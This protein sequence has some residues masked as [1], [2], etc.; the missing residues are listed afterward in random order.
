MQGIDLSHW[1][2][3]PLNAV[4]EKAFAESDFVI[5]KLTNGSDTYKYESWGR[6]IIERALKEGKLAG[7]YHYAKGGDP[8]K[9]AAEFVRAV[10]PYLGRIILALDWERTGNEAWGST[11]WAKTFADAVHR[12]TGVWPLIYTGYEGCRQC[13]SCFPA[14]GLWYA[15]YK[16]VS[17]WKV[18]EWNAAWYTAPWNAYTIWQY[19]SSGGVDRNTSSLTPDGWRALCEQERKENMGKI[20]T[21][22]AFV[23]KAKHYIGY[24]EKASAVSLEDFHANRGNR[25]Y[26][27]FQKEV[28]AGNGSAWCQYFVDACAYEACG[29]DLDKAREMLCMP[30]GKVMSGYTKECAGFFEKAGRFYKVPKVGDIVYFYYS[31]MG[32][33]AH[34]GIVVSVDTSAKT[35]RTVEGN[36][37]SSEYSRNGGAVAGHTYSYKTVGGTA[38][39]AG[40]GRPKF[41]DGDS[42]PDTG[43]DLLKKGASGESVRELQKMLIAC[44]YSCGS[45]GADGVFGRGTV[46][47]LKAF[48]RK[49]GLD[50]DGIYGP[51]SREALKKAYTAKNS[52]KK[53]QK[54]RVKEFQAWMNA[55]YAEVLL[56]S[57]RKSEIAVD[58]E[59]GTE[60]RNAALGIWKYM[61]A[62]YFGGKLTISNHAFGPAC[63]AV[64]EKMK[65]GIGYKEHPTLAILMQ[66]LLACRGDYDYAVDGVVGEGTIG[67]LKRY[68]AKRLLEQS[69]VC[70]AATWSALFY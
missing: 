27:K 53:T 33:I 66:G 51:K 22:D 16:T 57:V 2:G 52:D 58:G 37:S 69:G 40:F 23:A 26:T 5:A 19:T 54:D 45:A 63:R 15:R 50:A 25:N 9:E 61:A 55:H 32:R 42:G 64:A 28:G 70:D 31:S 35:F 48:Q 17:T 47:A 59:Y 12:E 4:S 43:D 29:N 49:S 67:C 41:A 30:A 6:N 24:E 60:T 62:K 8:E 38:H 14:C 10:R 44:G 36:T 65:V 20:A 13:A 1:N 34:T 39:V 68:Q 7:A 18:P 56:K 21:K 3:T 11:A 46:T